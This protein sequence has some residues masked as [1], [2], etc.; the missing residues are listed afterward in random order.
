MYKWQGMVVVKGQRA[1]EFGTWTKVKMSDH[2]Y[3]IKP[4][5]NGNYQEWSGEMRALLMRNGLFF[6]F[7]FLKGKLH[8]IYVHTQGYI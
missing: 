2:S 3:K 7:F 5:S 1:L 6:F 4:L 8:Q